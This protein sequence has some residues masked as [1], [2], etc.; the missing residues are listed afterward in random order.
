MTTRAV[1]KIC[2]IG[3]QR[4]KGGLQNPVQLAGD[5]RLTIGTR[6]NADQGDADLD[7]RQEMGRV[8]GQLQ[9][10]ARALVAALGPALQLGLAGRNDRQLGH[11]EQAVEHHEEQNDD[12]GDQ[13]TSRGVGTGAA[14]QSA[15]ARGDDRGKSRRPPRFPS[16]VDQLP[17]TGLDAP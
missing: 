15:S 9:G 2:G 16:K 6:Q 17:A 14:R 13:L 3:G 4:R 8:F 11:G 1:E 5:R 7:R 12:N 10:G